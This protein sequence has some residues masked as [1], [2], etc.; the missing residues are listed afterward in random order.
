MQGAGAGVAGT[1]SREVLPGSCRKTD[2][3]GSCW[4]APPWASGAVVMK[5]AFQ[6]GG[7]FHREGESQ[8]PQEKRILSVNML[9]GS[10]IIFV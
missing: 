8:S 3:G 1:L 10:I 2:G 7:S 6:V 4:G 9:V 5:A